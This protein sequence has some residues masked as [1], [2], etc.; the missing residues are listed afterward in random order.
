MNG[1]PWERSLA[2]LALCLGS[3]DDDGT[4]FSLRL[5][6]DALRDAQRF[7]LPSLLY[8]AL[9]DTRASFVRSVHQENFADVHADFL[10]AL[11]GIAFPGVQGFAAVS[12]LM[13]FGPYCLPGGARGFPIRAS[14]RGVSQAI[15][16]APWGRNGTCRSGR[17]NRA[18]EL[19]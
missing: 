7:S 18:Q 19:I 16:K 12:V 13:P 5:C 3:F 17:A 14:G 15:L 4:E 6:V 1:R 10:C 11:C 9:P 8:K 2:P